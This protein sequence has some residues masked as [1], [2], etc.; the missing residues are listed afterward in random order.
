MPDFAAIVVTSA[1]ARRRRR[2]RGRDADEV[3]SALRARGLFVESLTPARA[4]PGLARTRLPAALVILFFR[5]MEMLLSSGILLAEAL[6]GLQARFPDPRARRLL[7]QVHEEVA[8]SRS[9]LSAAL[10]GFPRTFPPA[11][12]AVIAAGEDGGSA[13]LAERFGDLAERVAYEDAHRRQLRRACAYPLFVV[14]LALGLQALLLGLVFP[15]LEELLGSLG[16]QLPPLTRAVIGAADGARRWSLPAAGAAAAALVLLLGARRL[17][18]P[19]LW[20]DRAFLRAPVVG[21]LYRDFAVALICKI[22]RSLYQAGQPAP[23]ILEAC[24]PLVA[25]EA[26]RAGLRQAR[27]EVTQ[28]GATLSAA[29]GATGL[30]PPLACLAVEVGEKSGRLAD[31]LE[32]VSAY[33]HARARERLAAAIALVNPALTLAVVG[34]TG[35]VMISFFQALYQVVYASA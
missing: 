29:L 11:I 33:F 14:G 34:A 19:R 32:R 2:L 31:A 16:G 26:F 27:R 35:L 15:R 7:A 10:A 8:G 28:G 23:E 17:A 18:A 25:N 6:D 1:G 20:L 13:L 22:Y 9:R 3:R 21:G 30:F 5:Q 12:V 24:V 4:R